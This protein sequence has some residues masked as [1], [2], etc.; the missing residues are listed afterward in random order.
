MDPDQLVKEPADLDLHCF[1]LSLYLVS[2]CFQKS[3]HL[4]SAQEG[5]S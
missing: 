2:Y 5:L 1:K 4:A 3:L